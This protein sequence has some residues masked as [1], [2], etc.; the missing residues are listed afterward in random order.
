MTVTNRHTDESGIGS[1]SDGID[2]SPKRPVTEVT[3][4]VDRAAAPAPRAS[5]RSDAAVVHPAGSQHGEADV[6]AHCHGARAA[7]TTAARLMRLGAKLAVVVVSPAE[8]T[9]LLIQ[10]AGVHESRGNG[11]V[12]ACEVRLR[13]RR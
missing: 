10:R 5:A 9:A 6:A 1:D 4:T 12:F 13:G 7:R 2:A 11:A 3:L 8:R